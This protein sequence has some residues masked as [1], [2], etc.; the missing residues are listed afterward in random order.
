[1]KAKGFYVQLHKEKERAFSHS[2]LD[3]WSMKLNVQH[4]QM[5]SQYLIIEV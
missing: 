2:A 5:I 3:V 1:M 4:I